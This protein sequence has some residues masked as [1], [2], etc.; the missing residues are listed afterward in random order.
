MAALTHGILQKFPTARD[1]SFTLSYINSRGVQAVVDEEV[2][3]Q[4][5]NC[6]DLVVEFANAGE[7]HIPKP[8]TQIGSANLDWS[9]STRGWP[10]DPASPMQTSSSLPL[11]EET[12]WNE[13]QS[14]DTDID[15]FIINPS[16]QAE[17]DPSDIDSDPIWLAESVESSNF[18]P[19][20][21][22]LS[23]A[24]DSWQ[25][26][27]NFSEWTPTDRSSCQPSLQPS[28]VVYN[29]MHTIAENRTILDNTEAVANS[30]NAVDNVGTSAAKPK[31]A[32][33]GTKLKPP[34]KRPRDL[35]GYE[36]KIILEKNR[37]AAAKCR[38]Q[39]KLN[40][41]NQQGQ[42]KET[43]QENVLLQGTLLELQ[44]Q[45]DSMTEMLAMHEACEDLVG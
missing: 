17:F 41:K 10:S 38:V 19:D 13:L 44:A 25:S 14:I 16:I 34:R 35:K 1:D 31:S 12:F 22:V 43:M 24:E 27:Y 18:S 8:A 30:S 11:G 9:K 40:E 21:R 2:V 42:L 39:R 29:E 32:K 4:L 45:A 7:R 33:A 26:F 15:S 3:H 28:V 5:S 37:E 20:S 23:S 6:Q 36:R